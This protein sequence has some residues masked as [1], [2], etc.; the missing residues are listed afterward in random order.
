MSSI[1]WIGLSASVTLVSLLLGILMLMFRAKYI[2]IEVRSNEAYSYEVEE[3]GCVSLLA[4]ALG[5][6]CCTIA[7]ISFVV[8]LYQIVVGIISSLS[9]MISVAA[10]I[11][12]VLLVL[13]FGFLAIMFVVSFFKDLFNPPR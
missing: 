2:H 6:L 1:T 9:S 10:V 5:I 7:V 12:G 8:L 11:Y 3:Y 4:T 13:A